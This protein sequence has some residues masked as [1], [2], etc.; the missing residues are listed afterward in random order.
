MQELKAFGAKIN[1]FIKNNMSTIAKK[2][3]DV[4]SIFIRLG[5]AAAFGG[6]L[7]YK[8]FKQLNDL[9]PAGALKAGAAIAG[10]VGLLSMGPVGLF[11]AGLLALL[12]LL[13]DFKTWERGGD[14]LLGDVWEQLDKL[15]STQVD[16]GPWKEGF[17]NIADAIG[18]MALNLGDFLGDL[19]TLLGL[20]DNFAQLAQWLGNV[21]KTLSDI[22]YLVTDTEGYAEKNWGIK[23]EDSLENKSREMGLVTPGV[24]WDWLTG[25]L[26]F[27][28]TVKEGDSDNSTNNT[29]YHTTITV[30]TAKDADLKSITAQKTLRA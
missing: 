3:A 26:P 20:E 6:E 16:L 1:S 22:I 4:L 17:Q 19:N 2:L 13:D 11:V 5:Q 27:G 23:K 28:K 12:L 25:D 21:F 10:F 7:I 8:L 29:T 9:L 15:N 24:I 30:P 18:S 14:A